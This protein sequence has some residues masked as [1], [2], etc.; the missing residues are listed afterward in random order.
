[1]DIKK[2]KMLF[3]ILTHHAW[4]HIMVHTQIHNDDLTVKDNTYVYTFLLEFL[5]NCK[6]KVLVSINDKSFT[7][8]LY[9]DFIKE[10]YK[11]VYQQSHI[12]FE[13]L[14]LDEKWKKTKKKNWWFYYIQLLSL[15]IY[16][17]YQYTYLFN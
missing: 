11:H 3:Y 10:T 2:M 8:Y 15:Y 4:I 12:N 13:D 1:M 17:C 7:K 16:I 6:C 14:N 9:K 5:K